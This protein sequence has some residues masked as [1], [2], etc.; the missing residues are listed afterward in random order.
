[1]GNTFKPGHG[2][3][4]ADYGHGS[5]YS[6]P[7]LSIFVNLHRHINVDRIKTVAVV[8]RREQ[9]SWSS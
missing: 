9:T 5:A 7:Q 8:K 1:M 4:E 6:R 3:H 2:G